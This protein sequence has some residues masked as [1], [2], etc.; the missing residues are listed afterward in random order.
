MS[1]LTRT[2]SGDILDAGKVG[3]TERSA[4]MRNFNRKLAAFFVFCSVVLAMVIPAKR[5]EAASALLPT[6]ANNLNVGLKRSSDVVSTNDGYMRVFCNGK[7]IGIE[8]Y[9]DDFNIKS[10]K[11]IPMELNLW[12]GFYAGSD[13]YYVVEGQ[14]NTVES[15]TAEVI[16][17]IRYDSN[18]NRTGAA[19]ITSNPELFGG[20]VRYPFD[21]GCVEMTESNGTLYIVT[22]HEGYVDPA[23]NQGHQGFLMIAVNQATMTGKIVDC[24]LWHSFAQYIKSKDSDLYVLE[25]SEGSRNTKLSKYNTE[26]LESTSLSVLNYGGSRD[27]AWAIACYASVDG[28]ALSADH[29]LCLGTSIDQSNYDS[30][31]SDTAH[32]IYLTVTPMSDFTESATRVVWLTNYTGGGKSFLGTKITKIN[33]NRF[34]VSWEEYGS[35]GTASTD[36]SLSGSILHYVFVDGEGNKI[37]KEYTASTPIS[38]CQPVVKNSKVVYYASNENAVN[39]YSIDSVTGKADKKGYRVAGENAVWELKNG[40]LTISGTG[41]VSVDPE[42]RYRHPV[43]SALTGYSYSS[44]DNVWKPIRNQVEKIVIKKGI[45]SIPEQAFAYFNNLQEVEIEP[46]LVSIGKEAFYGCNSLRKI[47]IPSSVKTI[48]KDILWTGGYWIFNNSHVNYAS[49]YTTFDSYAQKYAEKNGIFYKIDLSKAKVSGLKK[50]YIYNGK[51]QKPKVT[52]KLGNQTLKADRDFTVSYKNHKEV[53]TG[54]IYI[55]GADDYYGKIALKFQISLPSKGTKLTDSKTKAVYVVTKKGAEVALSSG[56]NIDQSVLRIPSSIKLNGITYRVTSVKD[57]AFKNHKKI[58]KVII[59][60]AVQSIGTGAFQGCTSLQTIQIGSQ[61]K[62]IGTKAFYGCKKLNSVTLGKN[63]ESIGDFSFADCT[64]L[65]KITLPTQ[66][67]K[68]GNSAFY[69]CTKMSDVTVQTEKLSSKN[70]GSKAF[71]KLGNNNSKKLTVKVPKNRWAAYRK[72]FLKR[73]LSSKTSVLK[74]K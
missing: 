59:S 22:G 35:E 71:T 25:Q 4:S 27:S 11:T 72:A 47:T 19:S 54:M 15:D 55:T 42:V 58:K 49:I 44:S 68:I 43:S 33:D 2:I 70:I 63:V 10:K 37:S 60:G 3:K 52:V 34:M 18:W 17:V 67:K 41:A 12:G 38:D 5:T 21:Y 61:V 50:S 30:V 23:Y 45:T 53:G 65:G 20:E 39:F 6:A 57:Y 48:G 7:T 14:K 51:S 62:T 8:Y 40:V 16:R 66:V 32:N 13:G 69:N 64:S 26:N 36:D 73:G 74:I 46:G 9:D 28:M 31:S 24:D 29:V 56:K 1:L